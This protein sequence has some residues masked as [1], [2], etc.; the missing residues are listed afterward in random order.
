MVNFKIKFQFFL[1]KRQM[2][3]RERVGKIRIF[4]FFVAIT[5]V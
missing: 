5:S 4:F 3:T 2:K 1:E